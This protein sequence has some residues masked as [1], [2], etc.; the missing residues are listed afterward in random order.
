MDA[1]ADEA[2]P[3]RWRRSST[4]SPDAMTL[5]EH[6]TELRRR[7][8]VGVIGFL[9]AAVVAF[10]AYN[11]ILAFLKG[12]YCHA[13]HGHCALYVT[14]PLDGLSLRIKIAAF[15]GLVLASPILLF[16]LWRFI[17][18]GLKKNEK[19]YA[20]P[21]VVSSVVLFLCGVAVAYVS[22]SHALVF[23][24][25]IGGPGLQEIY[26]PNQYLSL[27]IWMMIIFGL[28][29]E[30]PVL[31]VSL[32]LARVVTP[33]QL[34]GWWRWAIISITVASAVFTPSGDPLSMLALA[35]PLVAFYFMAIGIGKLAR[36]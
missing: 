28:T 13:N 21:F 5:T 16:E 24:G 2:A 10:L 29:F 25:S 18:P 9:I 36:R 35:V 33:A 32:E 17:T 14:S 7:L 11:Q 30:F 15:G 19:R 34:L 1:E 20:I 26:N 23:L 4:S 3:S 31:L 27:I 12:P 8:L 6:L 22:F